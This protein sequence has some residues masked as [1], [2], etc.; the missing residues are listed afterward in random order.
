MPSRRSPPS[1]TC[2]TSRGCRSTTT[3]RATSTSSRWP[4]P[5]RGG[6]EAARGRRGRGRARERLRDRRPRPRQH[7]VRLHVAEIFP[8]LPEKL[9]TDL[10]SLGEARDRLAIV[11]EMV[12]GADGAVSGSDVYRAL[13][14]NRA[15][16]AYNGVAAW[17]DGIG[18]RRQAWPRGRRSP[19]APPAGARGAGDEGTAPP[20]GRPDPGDDGGAR[21]IR[22]GAA[23]RPAAGREEPGEGTHRG[24]H[25][26]GERR[27]RAVPRQR[28]LPLAAA[29]TAHARA[30]GPDRGA[31]GRA[32]RAAHR[33]AD[34]PALEAFLA[35]RR[36]ADP[37][38]FATCRSPSSSCWARASTR[39]RSPAARWTGTSALR[40]RTTRTPRRRT[41][42]SRT[43]PRN[44][45]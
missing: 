14:R 26:R 22:R 37:A 5:S 44:A 32:R 34:A 35:R 8:M 27:D 6:G 12:V 28:G 1:A 23:G 19:T 13:V 42:A 4:S 11:V 38:R 33:R 31:G 2:A 29:G 43:W 18:P 3:T 7:D 30:V 39:W 21:R 25:D 10:T 45:W 40:S 24:L 20:P 9:S 41:A 15:K 36:L 17:L 16:L